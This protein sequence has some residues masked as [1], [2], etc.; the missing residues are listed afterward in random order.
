MNV[1]G[2]LINA[3]KLSLTFSRDAKSSA[4]RVLDE[5]SFR[6]GSGEFVSIVGP[7]GCG[8]STLLRVIAGLISATDGR[9]DWSS[10]SD[11]DA[12]S[13]SQDSIRPRAA[14]VF[15]DP[16]L[17]PWRTAARNVALPLELDGSWAQERL[18][19]VESTL[20][21]VGLSQSDFEKRP[22]Q[23]SGG[24]RMRVSLARALVTR[25]SLLLLDEPFAALDDLLR[26]RLN[27]E[28]QRL[29]QQQGWT[30]VLVTHNV[31][32]AVFMSQRVLVLSDKPARLI[33]EVSVP[34]KERT[35]SLQASAEFA[36]LCGE[37][38][39]LLE[40]TGS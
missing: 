28:L 38:S 22:R 18:S 6:I 23:L 36:H 37:V 24:M 5:L 4:D 31:A 14:F 33:H 13:E 20:Q 12:S 25:P 11:G 10:T 32:E 7:S 39:E 19:E 34:F 9:L 16:T 8:K 35:S 21:L 30:G 1:S 17:L 26:Q 2:S 3:E 29:W 27:R 15:Q 40:G